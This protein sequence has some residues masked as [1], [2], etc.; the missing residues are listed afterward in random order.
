MRHKQ[1]RHLGVFL[2][3]AGKVGQEVK[4]WTKGE[5]DFSGISA[6]HEKGYTGKGIRIANLESTNPALP[7]FHGKIRDPFD[8][9]HSDYKNSHGTNT[10]GCASS[11]RTWSRDTYHTKRW[12]IWQN[13]AKGRFVEEG[14]PYLEQER[15]HLVNASLKGNNSRPLANRILRAQHAGVT[16]V[17]SAGNDDVGGHRR[18]SWSVDIGWGSITEQ[19]GEIVHA[20]YS[21][22]GEEVDFTQ[23]GKLYVHD[24]RKGYEWRT[25]LVYGTSFSSPMLCGMLALVQQFFLEKA[26]RTLNQDELYGIHERLQYRP[27]GAWPRHK[28]RIRTFCCWKSWWNRCLEVYGG[29][30]KWT[31]PN[32]SS[33]Y[34]R[35]PL[36]AMRKPSAEPHKTKGWRDIGYH[37]IRKGTEHIAVMVKW[38]RQNKRQKMEPTAALMVWTGKV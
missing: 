30:I 18:V 23:F 22:V 16:F 31:I 1:K 27:I 6:W 15:I 13:Y 19:K 14:I 32:T 5:F 3:P 28:V 11:S 4:L 35:L 7:F 17:N 25:F 10:R 34:K 38:N 2:C 12:A 20:Q 8:I 33:S 26:G 37:Y 29:K 9:C 36:K 21:S 24:A